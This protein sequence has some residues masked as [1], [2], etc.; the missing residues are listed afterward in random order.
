MMA[1]PVSALGGIRGAAQVGQAFRPAGGQSVSPAD[2]SFEEAVAKAM[3]GTAQQ[4]KDAEAMA[5]AGVRGEAPLQKVV[6]EVMAAEQ[7]L[8]AAIAVRDKVVAAYLE[9]SRMAI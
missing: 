8:Q 9:I 3:V 1:D 4:L 5:V 6:E 2:V 7:S